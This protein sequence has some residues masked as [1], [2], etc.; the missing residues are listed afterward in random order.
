MQCYKFDLFIGA[1][2]DVCLSQYGHCNFISPKHAMVFYDEV[3]IHWVKGFLCNT[4]RANQSLALH[5]LGKFTL[6]DCK[7][8]FFLI[9]T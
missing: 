7:L 4:F 3:S 5:A 9:A 6:I 1:D 2:M 8:L